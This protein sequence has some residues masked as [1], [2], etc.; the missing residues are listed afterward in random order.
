MENIDLIILS[1][2]VSTLFLVF[3]VMIYRETKDVDYNSYRKLKDGG[4]RVSLVNF[5]TNMLNSDSNKKMKPKQR[6]RMYN[7]VRRTIADMESDG[8]YFTPEIKQELDKKRKELICEY[9]NL[10][11]VLSYIEDDEYPTGHS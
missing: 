2:I 8:V 9:S 1:T 11:S 6:V 10:P 7:S 3:F 4:P 5:L